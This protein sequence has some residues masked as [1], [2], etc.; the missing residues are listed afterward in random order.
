MGTYKG[1]LLLSGCSDLSLPNT[2]E[3]KVLGIIVSIPYGFFAVR[4]LEPIP[5]P[6]VRSATVFLRV[7]IYSP[8]IFNSFLNPA[9][10]P[11]LPAY[12]YPNWRRLDVP[13]PSYPIDGKLKPPV[14]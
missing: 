10:L 1:G 11:E 14:L 3:G 13:L 7:L 8:V 12:P 9:A 4:R 2:I 6:T 5:P